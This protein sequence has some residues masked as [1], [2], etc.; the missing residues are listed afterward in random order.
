M[1]GLVDD[2][3]ANKGIRHFAK[4]GRGW[5]YG[6]HADRALRLLG[7]SVVGIQHHETRL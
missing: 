2:H 3:V 1:F 7:T 6:V 4:T 5:L